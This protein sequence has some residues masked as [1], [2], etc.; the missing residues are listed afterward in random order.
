M[1]IKD[2]IALSMGALVFIGTIAYLVINQRKKVLEW[3]KA[4]V[5]EAEKE[6]GEKTGQ[7]KLRTVYDWFIQKFPIIA[8]V[9]PFSVFSAW[10]DIALDTMEEWLKNESVK[11]YV[12]G[13]ENE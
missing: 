6:L 4:A 12:R 1:E 2:V 3:L 13:E 9:L 7:L 10:V 8:T 11:T 5:T